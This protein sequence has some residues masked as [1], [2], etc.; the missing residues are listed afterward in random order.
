MSNLEKEFQETL[1]RYVEGMSE[2]D[3][4]NFVEDIMNK[5]YKEVFFEDP[6]YLETYLRD[7][8]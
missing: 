7:M 8:I 4:D 5:K 3:I 2:E 1:D 6:T